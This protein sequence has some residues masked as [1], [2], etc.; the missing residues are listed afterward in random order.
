MNM[1]MAI[2]DELMPDCIVDQ[3]DHLSRD[4]VVRKTVA[5]KTHILSR[6]SPIYH[7]Q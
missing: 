7:H 3:S 4:L 1:M 2:Y 5:E 6:L